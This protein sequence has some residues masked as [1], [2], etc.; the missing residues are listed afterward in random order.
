MEHA[1]FHTI[2]IKPFR[3]ES[4]CKI[5]FR[6]KFRDQFWESLLYT[7]SRGRAKGKK[8]ER[9]ME[10][11]S[12]VSLP[13]SLPRRYYLFSMHFPWSFF[14]VGLSPWPRPTHPRNRRISRRRKS[15]VQKYDQ[16]YVKKPPQRGYSG[17]SGNHHPGHAVLDNV[18]NKILTF[19]SMP[20]CR[21]DRSFRSS[22]LLPSK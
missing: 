10:I 4:T 22:L 2:I 20:N 18:N 8:D 21:Y 19:S 5:P 16:P 11:R 12:N 9:N 1:I 14:S 6:S 13:P 7:V 17:V 3:R 15:T